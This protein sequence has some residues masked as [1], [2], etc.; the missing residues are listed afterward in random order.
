MET[1][2]L[3]SCFVRLIVMWLSHLQTDKMTHHQK[4]GDWYEVGWNFSLGQIKKP[5]KKWLRVNTKF[6]CYV[7]LSN[8][9]FVKLSFC[10]IVILSNCH[11]V[12]LSFCQIVILPI[13]H[14]VYLYK[15]NFQWKMLINWKDEI[16][17]TSF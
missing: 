5:D 14:F 4:L 9:H 6:C 8:C 10:Q 13:R 15:N 7:I 2:K 1:L 12:K 16:Y 17:L 11:F 3:G